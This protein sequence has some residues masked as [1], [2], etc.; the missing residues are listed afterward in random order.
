MVKVKGFPYSLPSYGYIRDETSGVESYPYPIY[1]LRHRA[2]R[3]TYYMV[4]SS[5]FTCHPHV[6]TRME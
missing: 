5:S 3:Q 1:P 2:I 4:G 6:Y